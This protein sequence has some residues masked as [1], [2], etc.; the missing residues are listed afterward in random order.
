VADLRVERDLAASPELVWSAFT[1]AEGLAAWMWPGGWNT[2]AEV[3]L[4]VGG[5]Y[6][7]ESGVSGMG[8]SGEFESIEVPHHLEQTWRWDDDAEQTLVTITLTPSASGTALTIV[9]AG[10]STDENRD[11]HVQGWNDCLDRLE[12][13]LLAS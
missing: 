5:R 13:Y 12:P 1:S 2:T 11:N 6:R 3:D 8:V 7:I 4:R 10:F 9:H